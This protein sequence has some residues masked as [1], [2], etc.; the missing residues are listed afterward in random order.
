MPRKGIAELYY[1][2][3]AF[4]RFAQ[5]ILHKDSGKVNLHR[6]KEKGNMVAV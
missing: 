2:L 6:I 4:L 1:V 5:Q 3:I